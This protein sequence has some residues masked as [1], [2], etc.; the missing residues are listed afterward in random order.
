M[1]KRKQTELYR[2]HVYV[3]VLKDKICTLDV[4]FYAFL[5]TSYLL[6]LT[7]FSEIIMKNSYGVSCS[8]SMQGL[9]T[10]LSFA[11]SSTPVEQE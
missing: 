11:V 10:H 4:N 9:L 2:S 3:F 1:L 8:T 6:S 7:V 5:E